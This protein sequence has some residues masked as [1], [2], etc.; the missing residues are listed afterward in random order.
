MQEE[1]SDM[2][3]LRLPGLTRDEAL[4]SYGRMVSCGVSG[5][6]AKNIH[7]ATTDARQ[8]CWIIA[9]CHRQPGAQQAVQAMKAVI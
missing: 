2:R 1:V 8:S 5:E 7:Q 6:T 4:R 9:G 3:W